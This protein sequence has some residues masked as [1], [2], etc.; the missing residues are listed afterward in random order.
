MTT[1]PASVEFWMCTQSKRWP[2]TRRETTNVAAVEAHKLM[3][4]L[5]NA[6]FCL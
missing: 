5:K 6:R 4:V 3:K 1:P 2:E